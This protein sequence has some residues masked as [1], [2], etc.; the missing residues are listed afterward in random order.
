MGLI[1]SIFGFSFSRKPDEIAVGEGLS[2][3]SPSVI[4]F[5][6]PENADGASVLETGGFMSSVYDFGGSFIDEN[7]LINQYRSMSLYPEVDMAIEDI[8]TESIV[9]DTDDVA[10][11]LNL[12]AVMLSDN[13]K[14][15]VHSEFIQILKMLDFKNKGYEIFRRW[16]IESK[17]YYQL[18]IDMQNPEKGIIELRAIDPTKIR[19]VRKVE[20]ELKK[21]G[22]SQVPVIKK[23][24]EHFVYTE[25][26]SH[27]TLTTTAAGVKISPDSITYCNSGYM[28]QTTKKV[29]GYLHKA[30][31]PLNMLRQIEDA[32][33]IYRI[34]RAPER[35]IFYVDVG[36]LPKQKAEQYL[37]D[38]M[39][40]YR[41]KLVYDSGTGEI[42]DTRNHMSMLEDFWLPRREGGR[43]T[44]ISTLPGGQNLGEMEDVEYLLRKLY[45]SLNVPLTRM[46][47]QS[48]FN[49]GRSSEITRDEV[50][51]YKFIER[52]RNKFSY[53]FMDILKKQCL[54]K[55]IMTLDDWNRIYYDIR[56]DYSTDSYFN[57]LKENEIM[58]E[59]VEML[60][61]LG[62]FAGSLFS[63][64]YIRKKILKQT[65]E[66]IAEMDKE[67]E[68]ERQQ[69]MQQQI[70][71]QQLGLEP[72]QG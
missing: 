5:I 9:F 6:A 52:L 37:K 14:A 35:R 30:I 2:G 50:K 7:A 58:R 53:L 47:V 61:V 69:Q 46:E 34:S 72:E 66:E 4:S 29:V 8:I 44:E 10:V 56:F 51:F 57:E 49:L 59:K 40:K 71:M 45:R 23:V 28:D 17:L 67:M 22:S 39:L 60:S 68:Q 54:L 33:V 62:N 41:N 13:I 48:G 55:G 38:L 27:A 12:D 1:D 20:K 24:E 19:K 63:N 3:G 36:N 26:D 32:V 21:V 64:K 31:R 42:K 43:G 25:I 15:K 18:I 65:D 70:Q 11:K 16:Y